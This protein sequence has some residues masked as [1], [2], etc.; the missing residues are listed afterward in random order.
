VADGA[1]KYQAS[2]FPDAEGKFEEA[3]VVWPGHE[4]ALEWLAKCRAAR[5]A[6]GRDAAAVEHQAAI[7]RHD[8]SEANKAVILAAAKKAAENVF[9]DLKARARSGRLGG[10]S[11]FRCKSVSYGAFVW[12]R[13]A[14][15]RR[16]W[17]FPARAVQRDRQAQLH[18]LHALVRRG[19][20]P[21]RLSRQPMVPTLIRLRA[22]G[23]LL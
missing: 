2:A 21:G 4:A 1:A 8:R 10:L 23:R 16:K 20:G 17:R 22:R 3:L 18:A 13:R 19:A 5:E 7:D 12:T 15:N 6:A 14:L 11:I 9:A